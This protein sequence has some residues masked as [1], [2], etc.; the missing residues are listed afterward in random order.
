[1]RIVT[2]PEDYT[3]R[4]GHLIGLALQTEIL[5]WN[6]PKPDPTCTAAACTS[7]RIDWE[8]GKTRVVLPVVDAP[9]DP[10]A[11]FDPNP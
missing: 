7:V 9:G 2:K 4:K 1:M 5:E 6:I 10:A 11:L 3:F 8:L